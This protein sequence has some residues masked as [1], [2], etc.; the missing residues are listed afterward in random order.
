MLK[1]IEYG[2]NGFNIAFWKNFIEFF[3]ILSLIVVFT[4]SF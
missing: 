3:W 1:G 4:L 2:F